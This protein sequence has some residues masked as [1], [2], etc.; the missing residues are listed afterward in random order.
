M[1]LP[2]VI[3]K[4]GSEDIFALQSKQHIKLICAKCGRY[5]KFAN[6]NEKRI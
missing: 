5:I 2:G 3:C 6:K 1:R 4:C